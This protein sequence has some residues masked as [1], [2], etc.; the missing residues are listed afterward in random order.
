LRALSP[1]RK[2][3]IMSTPTPSIENLFKQCLDKDASLT[4]RLA[5]FAETLREWY[6]S[7]AEA[8]DRLIRRLERSGAGQHA[9]SLGDA[10]PPFLL[11]DDTGRL[12]SLEELLGK[13]PLALTFNRGHWCPYCRINIDALSMARREIAETGGQVAAIIPDR[14][15]FVMEFKRDAHSDLPIL[16]DIDN[17]Y[18]MSLG[19]A[20]WVGDEMKRA[21]LDANYD[22]ANFQGNDAWL[23]PIPATFVV[24]RDGKITARFIDPD[25]RRRMTTEEL[26]TALR[27]G[28]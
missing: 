18:A 11:P 1:C 7:F 13:G 4:E 14:Q 22:V 3:R 17:A 19:L 10:M 26:L 8:V 6:P 25:Y 24:G 28:I 21:M 23:L 5:S 2:A 9:P 20:F 27:E 16:I 15:P 12:V